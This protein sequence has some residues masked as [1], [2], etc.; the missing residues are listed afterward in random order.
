MNIFTFVKIIYPFIAL[1]KENSHYTLLY[2]S[3]LANYIRDATTYTCE[4]NYPIYC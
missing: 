4:Q 1:D 3:E 2:E